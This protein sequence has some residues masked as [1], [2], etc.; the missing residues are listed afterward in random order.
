MNETL[1]GGVFIFGAINRPE[2]GSPLGFFEFQ[3]EVP[4]GHWRTE[5]EFW[6]GFRRGEAPAVGEKLG[7]RE[8]GLSRTSGCP[9]FAG[10]R[11]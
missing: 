5:E 2:C 8:R 3:P 10:R 11:S 6:P 4:G 9:W 7:K 1:S